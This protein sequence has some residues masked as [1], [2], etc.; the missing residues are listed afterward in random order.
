MSTI[1]DKESATN[2]TSPIQKEL[3]GIERKCFSSLPLEILLKIV[4]ING[5]GIPQYSILSRTCKAPY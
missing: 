3:C 5:F 2:F 1:D 4:R